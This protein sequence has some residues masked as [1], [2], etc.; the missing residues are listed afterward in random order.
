MLTHFHSNEG[1]SKALKRSDV[2]AQLTAACRGGYALG[3]FSPRNTVL[4][5]AVIQAAERRRSPVMVQMS[6]NEMRWFQLT[7]REF[8]SA[9][10]AAAAK[11]TVPVILHLDHT[12]DFDTIRQAVEAGFDSV[13]IDGSK[14]AFEDN[15]A[16]TRQVT[17]Y[18]H[19]HDVAVEAELGNIGGADKLETG[20]DEALYTVPEQARTFVEETGCDTLAVSIGTAHGVYPTANPSIDFNRL[21]QI[22]RLIDT[23]LV[24]HG[25]SGLPMDTVRKAV[26]EG[27]VKLNIAT[28]LELIF[29]R[30]MNVSRM[31]NADVE[32]L[33][34]ALLAEAVRQ[35]GAFVE[36]R[37][38]TYLFSADKA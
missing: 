30:V 29:Q 36:N 8:A 26:Q 1:G 22:R 23:P 2:L 20:G 17:E 24:L 5:S 21:R 27:I 3:S 9:F 28:D 13:M 14:L 37:M 19:A 4:I 16:L 6:S 25:G 34:P 18:A 38:E 12:Y 32:K 31:P 33:D 10:R 35:V 11:A 15:I 7:P